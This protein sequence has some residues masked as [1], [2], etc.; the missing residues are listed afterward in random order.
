VG[1]RATVKSDGLA[2]PTSLFAA[3]SRGWGKHVL[4]ASDI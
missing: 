4:T 2:L 1:M 3:Q